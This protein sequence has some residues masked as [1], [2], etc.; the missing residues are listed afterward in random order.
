MI[1]ILKDILGIKREDSYIYAALTAVVVVHLILGA[2][3][4][5]AWKDANTTTM[6][7]KKE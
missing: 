6:I 5:A 7:K 4:Y 1:L 2:F 3:I